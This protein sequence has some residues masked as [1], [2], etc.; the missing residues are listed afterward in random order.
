MEKKT[1]VH[2]TMENV[3]QQRYNL[4]S[5]RY[6]DINSRFP[7]YVKMDVVRF[8]EPATFKYHL[9]TRSN[10]GTWASP[11]SLGSLVNWVAVEDYQSSM[12]SVKLSDSEFL[13]AYDWEDKGLDYIVIK[14][15]ELHGKFT[16]EALNGLCVIL[17]S[18]VMEALLEL[19]FLWKVNTAPV[20]FTLCLINS[21]AC[22]P[23]IKDK[24]LSQAN[25]FTCMNMQSRKTQVCRLLMACIG[26]PKALEDAADNILK[27]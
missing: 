2:A 4:K 15:S 10:F 3:S 9:I 19:S 5:R 23:L 18:E 7:S 26:V 22:C 13:I 8:I 27:D 14:R 1:M 20:I 24:H 11:E 25:N 6:R 21:K 17:N 16:M 12:A